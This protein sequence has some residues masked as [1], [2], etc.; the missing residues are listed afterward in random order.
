[1]LFSRPS[2]HG[3]PPAIQS[4]HEKYLARCHAHHTRGFKSTEQRT[5]KPRLS[6]HLRTPL[7]CTRPPRETGCDMKREENRRNAINEDARP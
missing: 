6:S 2:S 5:Q 7:I 4:A 3:M 1:M